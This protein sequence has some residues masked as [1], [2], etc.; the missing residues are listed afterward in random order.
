MTLPW[1]LETHPFSSIKRI[2]EWEEMYSTVGVRAPIW[3]RTML[4]NRC[5]TSFFP[6]GEQRIKDQKEQTTNVWLVQSYIS[7]SKTEVV[8]F[9][10]FPKQWYAPQN[11]S[12][13]GLQWGKWGGW[14]CRALEPVEPLPQ[15]EA[16]CLQCH[17]A[18]LSMKQGFLILPLQ[19]TS[20]TVSFSDSVT[21]H[22]EIFWHKK[23]LTFSHFL[24]S[25]GSSF[26]KYATFSF[27]LFTISAGLF[28]DFPK[29]NGIV[30]AGMCV[31]RGRTTETIHL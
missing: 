23:G 18:P 1:G 16:P 29:G 6:F 21:G 27:R 30:L 28:W 12:S 13:V 10:T 25:D 4:L 20:K 22:I 9:Q 17:I 31:G 19:P 14:C 26:S 8:V 7:Y 5:T 24:L 2:C 15:S 11:Q 3:R